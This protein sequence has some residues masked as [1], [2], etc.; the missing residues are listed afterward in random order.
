MKELSESTVKV[1]ISNRILHEA[2]REKRK[3]GSHVTAI[4][5]NSKNIFLS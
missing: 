2:A 3:T 5:Y 1:T 4:A